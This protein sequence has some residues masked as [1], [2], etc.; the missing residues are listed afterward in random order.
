[1]ISPRTIAVERSGIVVV[2]RKGI[3]MVADVRNVTVSG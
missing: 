3:A 1:L 2:S